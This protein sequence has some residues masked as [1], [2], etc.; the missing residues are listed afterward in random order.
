[1][2]FLIHV[3]LPALR[4][5]VL[6][7]AAGNTTA[8]QGIRRLVTWHRRQMATDPAYPTI[9][10]VVAAGILRLVVPN[11]AQAAILATLIAKALRLNPPEYGN[12]WNPTDDYL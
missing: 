6:T 1:M 2:L 12:G 5:L 8:Q 9:L 3:A 4:A 7:L 10:A 11:R